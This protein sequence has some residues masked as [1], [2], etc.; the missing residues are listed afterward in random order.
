MHFYNLCILQCLVFLL[1]SLP[2]DSIIIH[3]ITPCHSGLL[4]S[5]S[6]QELV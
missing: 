3:P 2:I 4:G 5:F 1:R 6:V